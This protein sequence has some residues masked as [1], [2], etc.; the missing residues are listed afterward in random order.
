MGKASGSN[1]RRAREG[2]QDEINM[3]RVIIRRMKALADEERPLPELLRLCETF[4]HLS[5]RLAQLLKAERAL[6]EG[7]PDVQAALD[8]VLAEMI[9]EL[10]DADA[11]KREPPVRLF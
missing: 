2:L 3:L 7:G 6:D 9:R 5:T 11:G 8:E 4:G 1:P 10:R